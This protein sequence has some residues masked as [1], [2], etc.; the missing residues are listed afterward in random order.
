MG[1]PGR[2]R[3]PQGKYGA[4]MADTLT[5]ALK[6]RAVDEGFDDIAIADAAPLP[7][8]GA[9]LAAWLGHGFHGTMAWMDR[10][11]E[12]RKDPSAVVPDCRS[13]VTVTMNYWR[14]TPK[15]P[16]DRFGRVARYAQSRDYHKVM[17]KRLK[18]LA[19]WLEDESGQATRA[20]VD[21]APILERGWAQQSGIGWIGKNANL[22]TQG[23]GSWLL[24]GEL[25]TCASLQ[26]DADG[27]HADHCGTCTACLDACPT[28]AIVADGVV[29]ATRCIS[30]WTIEHRGS[31]PESIRSGLDG[32][33]FGCDVCQDVCPWNERFAEEADPA[34]I[35]SRDDLRGLDPADL[36][37][38][39]EVTFR[40]RYSGTPLMRARWDGMRRNAAIVLGNQ[41]DRR[42]L[43]LLRKHREDPQP[44]IR[45]SVTWA[46]AQIEGRSR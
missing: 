18:H 4:T 1:W 2:S 8:D 42:H 35:E 10:H 14:E 29:D 37:D 23:R 36:L 12:R 31:I 41:G 19:Q 30:Y 28:D 45:E 27:P 26:A 44:H 34:S 13:V 25:L 16:P 46:I 20:F 3:G 21:T 40:V 17:G 43:E 39:D 22:L 11:P 32:W 9:A 7:R 24:L 5:D 38:L 15:P 6:R 33:V